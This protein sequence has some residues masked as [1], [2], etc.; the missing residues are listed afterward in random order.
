[1]KR[2]IYLDNAATTAT[3]PEVLEAMMPYFSEIYG[4]PSS[5]H[6][7]GRE[8]RKAVEKARQQVADAI[9]AQPREIYFTAG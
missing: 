5:I 2:R 8:G 1:M 4:N 7:F 6:G 3:R 9:G